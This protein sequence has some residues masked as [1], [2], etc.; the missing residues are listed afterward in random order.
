MDFT[1]KG[2]TTE[3]K[4]LS[5]YPLAKRFPLAS[6]SMLLPSKP[7]LPILRSSPSAKTDKIC[8]G[9]QETGKSGS[10]L[11]EESRKTQELTSEGK[12]S[13][14]SLL[15]STGGEMKKRPLGKSLI[16]RLRKSGIPP[17]GSAAG[18]VCSSPHVDWQESHEMR[19]RPSSRHQEMTLEHAGLS[20]YPLAK[21]F[22]LASPSMLLPS[23][24]LLPILRS[25]PSAKT[26]KI[27]HGEQET[28]KS[29]S[30]L[31]EESRKT[32]ELTSEGKGSKTSLLYST[33]G[34]MKKRPLGKSLIPRL[35]KSG[36][37]P[38]GSAAGSVC[39]S[40]HVDWQ[41][42]HE[43]RPRP[44]SRHQ[45]MTLEHEGL[46]GYPL[47]KRFPLA[48]PSMLLPSKPLL[49][50]LRNSPS[51]K[52]DKICHGEQ[53]TGKSGSGLDEESRKT[54]ELTSEGKGSK[55]FSQ[56]SSSGEMKKGSLEL[57][58]IPPLRKAGIPPV[59]T[60]AGSV[61]TS[62]HVDFQELQEMRPRPSTR[63][64]EKTLDHADLTGYTTAMSLAQTRP[65]SLLPI[66]PLP[67]IQE[68]PSSIK[69]SKV[70]DGE[71][72]KGKSSTDKK[73]VR[74]SKQELRAEG[75][76]HKTSLP[77]PIGREMKMGSLGLPVIPP[78]RKAGI[79][80]VD[81][82][83]GSVHRSLHV[84]FQELQE[85]RPRPSII[86]QE[87]TLEG[88]GLSGYPLA[89]RISLA[90]PSMLLPSKPL[91]PILRS[92]PSANTIK[93][94][95]REQE[96]GKSGS[97][98]DEERRKT[99]ELTSE[100]KGSKTSLLYS[101]G[102][103]LK[104]RPLRKSL[105][106]RLR[107]A[108]IPPV[109]SAAGSVPKSPQMDWQESRE[110]SSSYVPLSS[111]FSR[112][113]PSSRSQEKT[114]EDADLT[115]YTTAMSLAQTRPSSLLPIKPLPPIQERPSSIK[116]SK[117]Y[118]GEEEKGKSSTDKKD[119]RRS[120]QALRAEGEGHKTSLP[121]PIGREMKMGSLGLPV[122]PPIRKAGI[123]SVDTAA[124]SAH[125]SPH[126]DLQEL[127]EMR[128]RPSIISQEK[129][130]EGADLIGYTLARR[131]SLSSPAMLLPSK[132]LLPILRS[133]PFAMPSKMCHG[134]QETGKSGSG[135]D[136]ARRKTQELTSEGKGSKTSL[137]YSTGGEMKKRPLRKSL[138]PRLRKAGIPPVGSAAG[139]VPKSPQMDWQDSNEMR[140]RPSIRSQE[141]TPEDAGLPLS[142]AKETDDPSSPG[143]R[144]DKELRDSF[145]KIHAE[146]CKLAKEKLEQKKM[147][148][149][150]EA[151]KRRQ[152]EKSLQ[153]SPETV[154][155]GDAA[156][157]SFSLPPIN[158]TAPSVQR[159]D[160]GSSMKKTVVRKQDKVPLQ[161]ST[162]T[163][164]GDGSFPLSSSVTSQTATGAKRREEP[165]RGH[166][167]KD[168]AFSDPQQ[169][170]QEALSFLGSDDWERKKKGLL[171][172][173]LLAESHSEVLLCRLREICLAVTSEVSNL[174]SNV[175]C[176]AIVTLGE[177]FEILGKD[178]DSEV[179]EIAAVLL[180]MLRNSPE[181]IQ[182]AA[183]ESLGMMVENVTPIRAMT[184][185]MDKG[186]KSRYVPARKC[187]AELLLSLTEKMGVTK[188]AGTPRAER[189]AHVAGILAQDCHKDTRHY[190][191]EMVKMLLS[192]QKFKK[193]LEQSLSTHDLEDILKR[194]KK[195]GMDNQKAECPPVQEPVKKRNDG[196]KKPQATS[197]PSK[198]AKSA[199]DGHR[200]H[201]ATAQVT[202]PASVEERE[203][204][205]KL[206]HLLEDKGFQTR[207]E[208]VALLLDLSQ[209]RPQLITTNI[210]QIFDYFV[211]RICDTHKKV[212][213][214][215]LEA[216][217]EIIGLLQDAMN[218]LMIRLVEGIT[219]NL[220]S[221]DPGVHAAAVKALDQAVVHL[222]EV[223][224]MKELSHQ[225][226]QLSGQALLIVTERI[227]E[228]V[229]W[230]H[231]RSPEAVERYALPV[232][233]SCLENKALPVQ[234]ASVCTV[235]TKLACAL[236]EALGSR[237]IKFADSTPPHVQENLN[238]LL[239][240]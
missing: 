158:G 184:A 148:I 63:S 91:P 60:A 180:H 3:G 39:S 78:I 82:A 90:S 176:S 12:G 2:K 193:L 134:E 67:P 197:P 64:Q 61:H 232:L 70:Y 125:R 86:S 6:P 138:I 72:E 38:A 189:L 150:M 33:G 53:E 236:C 196:A 35:R 182:K 223:S 74:R 144:S 55:A 199:T 159:K 133:S 172:I 123:P 7:L 156:E 237:I 16:P 224:L 167:Q 140:P 99:Q 136:E 66:K 153:L 187:A 116:P 165:L 221:K 126:V 22:P 20:G 166:R 185:L 41:E 114:P 59:G 131:F 124:G 206:Y 8:H 119:V 40:P 233:W 194:M 45:E 122:I 181:F 84:D 19:P 170:L 117:M 162:P 115:G 69:P 213:Q 168:R 110:M 56:Y 177:L 97:S 89:K 13:K 227:T 58:L 49:P 5:G 127:Q 75:E 102:G 128:P 215:A 98:L 95:H 106:P 15:Y 100:R 173:T 83:A 186:V 202:L 157:A 10:G 62:L 4:G 228:L 234:S 220:N 101:T 34:E 79:P 77:C 238:S 230:V 132:P 239:G 18:S 192:N 142:Q 27:C 21:R 137:L 152:N 195:K 51:A 94:C 164:H 240:W 43:M 235:V 65:S 88:A 190:G 31:D 44:S 160:P 26:D 118:D 145:G 163:I 9:E 36:I 103:E 50:I 214:K 130:L 47:A 178:M 93:M 32:Q 85:M 68:R 183:C 52:T 229:E 24:P 147:K 129:T 42:S 211:L 217:A 209:T 37:P 17:A 212:K 210:V 57:P 161:P 11:D 139:S 204:L 29:G 216:L 14:T 71:E 121:C 73:D 188:L 87:K 207:M 219:K 201:R 141:K 92:S 23:K 28:G 205:Q 149:L 208:G 1:G 218:P 76:G 112:P 111:I 105:I 174:R 80:S 107:K 231:A 48:S 175:S 171:N 113:R 108:G 135:L 143:L 222:D 155:P 169:A 154:E 81:T 146:M 151:M 225:W 30:G 104:K 96:T 191:Q 179:D 200:L 198:R 109:G 120:K 46:S 226:S 25:S 203:L 54:Q